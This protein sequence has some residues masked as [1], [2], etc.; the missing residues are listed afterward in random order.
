MCFYRIKNI[1]CGASIKF[2]NPNMTETK[3]SHDLF[4]WAPFIVAFA[5]ALYFV[6]PVE[7]NITHPVLAFV[8]GVIILLFGKMNF[9]LR[10]A[11]LFLC[12]FLYAAVYT[13]TIIHTP[14]LKHDLR[15]VDIT[16]TVT[17]IDVSTE[18]QRLLLSVPGHDLNLN[19]D[20]NVNIKLTITGDDA[21]PNVG[22]V[23]RAKVAVFPPARMEAPETFDYAR[24][25]YFHELTA[26]GFFMDYK[27]LNHDTDININGT[28]NFIHDKA[29]SFLTDGLVLGYK[30]SVPK[31]DK[32]VW[33]IAGVGHI[34]SISGFHMTLIGGW[35]F[36]FFYFICRCIGFV[37]RR[38]PARI[39][40]TICAW[41]VLFLYVCI[42]G[43]SVATMRAFLMTSLLFLALLLGRN[44]LSM[45]NI[46]IAFLILFIINP[47]FVMQ[48]GFQLSFAAIFGLIWF[49][50]DKKFDISN[51]S[52]IGKVR[53]WIYVAA[54]TSI[55]ATLFTLPFIAAHFSSVPLYSLIGNLVLLPIFSMAIM[56]LV[57]LGT[58]SAVFGSHW[59][60]NVAMDIYNWSLHLATIIANLPLANLNMP[61]ISNT[62]FAIFIL[63]FV[64]L[65]LIRPIKNSGVLVLRKLNY[66]LF[67][68]TAAFGILVVVCQPRP[69]FYATH[70]HELIG[71]V[72][73]GKLEFN[74]ARA[75]NHY[76]A[77]DAF[78]QLN[79]EPHSDTNVRR[80]CPDG[81]CIYESPKFTVAYI[82]KFVP[83][84]K[85][86]AK[87]CRDENIDYI[88]SYFNID[89]PSCRQKIL[90]NG[91]V[92]YKSGHVKY[93]PVNRW[94]HNPHE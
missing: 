34:W 58:V 56:P 48:S 3:E 22:D 9:I 76:F 28:R 10:A 87:L 38:V 82:Q 33:T 83:L 62:A 71:M 74:K 90:R 6:M 14:I 19:T 20:K 42:S 41:V 49:F 51:Q 5:A 39:V 1:R 15:E 23:L 7:P 91:F 24:W 94:W 63:A 18:K 55:I 25:S 84:Q 68:V 47:H 65:I 27:I 85:H 61:H 69:V 67:G 86:F 64:F 36:A 60:L 72:Y 59:L 70:D 79:G 35:L 31:I 21:I 89:A 92:I 88:V 46:C 40:A 54:M 16:A 30:N 81:V 78:R 29:N 57:L 75:S 44:A 93:T 73:D 13:Q 66:V 32:D 17:D 50:G 4:L 8:S 80:K 11:V 26:T 45:R 12:G 2:Y 77:F 43:M 53:T 37:T 52:I